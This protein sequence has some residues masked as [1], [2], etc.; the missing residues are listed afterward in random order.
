[1]ICDVELVLRTN[2]VLQVERL[3]D[4][5]KAVEIISPKFVFLDN[6]RHQLVSEKIRVTNR[7]KRKKDF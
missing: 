4:Q 2:Q 5:V 1:V 7:F 3:L 6:L